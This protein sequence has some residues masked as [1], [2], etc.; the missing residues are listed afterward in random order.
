M[1]LITLTR[2][3]PKNRYLPC[4]ASKAAIES[5]AKVRKVPVSAV[6]MIAGLMLAM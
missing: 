1:Q 5:D 3:P 2:T 4:S 6:T